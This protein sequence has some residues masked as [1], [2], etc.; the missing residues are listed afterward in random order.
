MQPISAIVHN[1][2]LSL[3][4]ISEKK[5]FVGMMYVSID[6]LCNPIEIL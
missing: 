4:T 2:V 6:L 5:E 1:D 3:F